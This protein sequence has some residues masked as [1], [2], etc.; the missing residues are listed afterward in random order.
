LG[1]APTARI[2]RA[3]PNRN[4][5]ER[6]GGASRQE[7]CLRGDPLGHAGPIVQRM[8]GTR[9]EPGGAPFALPQ[10]LRFDPVLAERREVDH[11]VGRVE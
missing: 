9:G 3:L 6:S 10:R 4:R 11:Q 2:E 8:W 1:E 7:A 5:L